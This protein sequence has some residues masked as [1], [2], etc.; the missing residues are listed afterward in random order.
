MIVK[1]FPARPRLPIAAVMSGGG[2]RAAYQV[3]VL[4]AIAAMLPRGAANPFAIICGTSAG[5]IN[6]ASLASNADRFD[7]GVARLA[8]VWG[9]LH[10]NDVY[11]TDLS[12]L[13]RSLHRCLVALLGRREHPSRPLSLLDCGPL[14]SLLF[15]MIDFRRI[16][17]VIAAGHLNALSVT[18][19]SYATGDSVTFFQSD[20]SHKPWR[21]AHRVGCA[22]DI[23]LSHVMASCAL[24]ILF[25]AVRIGREHF[26]DGSMHQLAPISAALHLGARRVLAIGVGST[27]LGERSARDSSVWPS[28]AQITGHML[29][30]IFIDTLDMDLERLQRVNQT[31]ASVRE[32]TGWRSSPELKTIDTFIIRPTERMDMIAASH[33]QELPRA[34]RFLARRIGVMDPNGAGVLSYLLFESS[35]CR[36]LIDLGFSDAMSRRAELLDFL[37]Y[38]H[39]VEERSDLPQ[40][41]RQARRRE[42]PEPAASSPDQS[43]SATVEPT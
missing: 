18:A 39:S 28:L 22:A 34:M 13:A 41:R 40:K 11:R 7:A 38:G 32:N 42:V 3:G 27:S 14:G 9:N 24:P 4:R 12:G 19:S 2:A 15:R 37:G 8:R 23:G 21:R 16:Q 33:A 5:A 36:H 1:T 20:A 29:D 35:Y 6:A 25:P 43:V 30:A 17:R 26:G 10:V 31:L